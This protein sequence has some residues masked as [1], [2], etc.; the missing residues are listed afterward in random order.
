MQQCPWRSAD[1][2]RPHP[3]AS[4]AA[5]SVGKLGGDFGQQPFSLDQPVLEVRPDLR[6]PERGHPRGDP[7][8]GVAASLPG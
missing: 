1:G 4:A 2:A 3:A 5:P 7:L 6:E 8:L